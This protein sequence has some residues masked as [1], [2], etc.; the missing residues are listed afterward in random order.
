MDL[1]RVKARSTPTGPTQNLGE[2][3]LSSSSTGNQAQMPT[4]ADVRSQMDQSNVALPFEG[5]GF[6]FEVDNVPLSRQQEAMFEVNWLPPGHDC[7]I[8]PTDIGL[9]AGT[10]ATLAVR[11]KFL[12]GNL[13]FCIKNRNKCTH[14]LRT[15]KCNS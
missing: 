13:T 5:T 1:V 2:F 7:V 11:Q 15:F 4:L 8:I 3:S 9:D 12:F 10:A 14:F 6:L